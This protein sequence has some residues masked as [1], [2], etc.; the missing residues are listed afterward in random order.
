MTTTIQKPTKKIFITGTAG[1]IGYHLANTLL[2]EGYQV[3]GFDGLTDY[4]DVELKLRRHEMLRQH[5]N[6][7]SL[8]ACWKIRLVSTKISTVFVQMWWFI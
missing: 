2:S 8:S 1:F 6:L 5:Q 3:H 4:Y 7:R